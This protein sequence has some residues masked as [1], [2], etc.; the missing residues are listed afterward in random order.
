MMAEDGVMIKFGTDG[1][2]GVIA[3]DFNCDNVWKVACAI[4]RYTRDSAGG[5]DP[6]LLIGYDT[7]FGSDMFARLCAAAAKEHGVRVLISE[8]F[9]STP[10]MSLATKQLSARGAI[11]ITASHNPARF[12][13]VK[14]KGPYGGSATMDIMAEIE[15]RLREVEKDPPPRPDALSVDIIDPGKVDFFDPIQNYL[16]TVVSLV[17]K[18]VFPARQ[19]KVMFDPMWGA[20]QGLLPKALERLG[21][22]CAQIHGM[23]NPLF[24]GLMP[25][26]IGD[27]LNDLRDA[28]TGGGYHVG[29]AVDGDA[30]RVTA[31]DATGR[32]I[33]SHMVLALLLK[34]LVEIRKWSGD[35]V[36]TVSTT[37][38]IDMLCDRYGRKLHVTPVGFKHIADLM[39]EKDVLVGGEESGGTGMKNYIPERDGILIGLMLIEIMATNG[40]TLGQLVDELMDEL[41]RS[42]VFL[43]RDIELTRAH[44]EALL[45]SLSDLEPVSIGGLKVTNVEKL[46]GLKFHREDS[47]WLML[48]VSGTEPVVRVYA[49]A[50][51]QQEVAG[52]VDDGIE[53]I[54]T[55]APQ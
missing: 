27:N 15:A 38:M 31:I 36:K 47:S 37:T 21:M 22:E 48:R 30:D 2:R 4:A 6:L 11:M 5:D 8:R 33:S 52:L 1:W 14:F 32:F 54:N 18:D 40:K 51:S 43:R 16:D 23:H 39:L 19:F 25:E 28:V 44:K 12:N 24:P 29:I 53:L 10:S 42:F 7:R 35:V 26:P 50:G 55:V 46:D 9:T 49:E 45:V 3:D 20:G 13:G 41:G 17:N 34:H